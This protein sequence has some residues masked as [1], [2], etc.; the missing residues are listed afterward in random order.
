MASTSSR[1]SRALRFLVEQRIVHRQR[2]A[3]CE[4]QDERHVVGPSSARGGERDELEDAEHAAAGHKRDDDEILGSAAPQG[5]QHFGIGRERAK[6]VCIGNVHDTRRAVGN[7]AVDQRVLFRR[8][9]ANER[10]N[11]GIRMHDGNPM[12]RAI[13]RDHVGRA[14]LG[15]PRHRELGEIGQHLARIERGRQQ[16]RR[17]S[18]EARALLGFAHH[19]AGAHQVRIAGYE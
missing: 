3:S 2:G 6:C 15:D 19:F 11:A 8:R 14:Q 18:E 5:A 13:R 17:L 10:R 1:A 16:L 7:D 4:I 9:E 12:A